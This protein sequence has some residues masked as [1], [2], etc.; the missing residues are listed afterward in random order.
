M[1][2][3]NSVQANSIHIANSVGA[4]NKAPILVTEDYNHWATRFQGYMMGKNQEVWRS[5]EQGPHK[6]TLTRTTT[7][8]EA[9]LGRTPAV[10]L[11]K[12]AHETWNTLHQLFVRTEA[13]KDK[14]I[15]SAIN[16]FLNFKALPS[17]CLQDTSENLRKMSLYE[18]F[19]DLQA[20]ESTVLSNSIRSGGPIALLSAEHV[21][22]TSDH[23]SQKT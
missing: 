13:A 12:S 15:T 16:T 20:Q 22:A 7:E 23:A 9:T 11:C 14:K 19:N 4:P 21:G 2:N 5:I 6:P 10:T 1:N 8:V 17:E 3:M 18:L